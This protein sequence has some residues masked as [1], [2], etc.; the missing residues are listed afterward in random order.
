MGKSVGLVYGAPTGKPVGSVLIR[1]AKVKYNFKI[2]L[3]G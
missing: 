2:Q 3:P 1:I